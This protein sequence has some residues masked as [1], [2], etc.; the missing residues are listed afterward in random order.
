MTI[1]GQTT[2]QFHKVRLKALGLTGGAITDKFQFHKVRLKE[3]ACLRVILF[4]LVS[5][6]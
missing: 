4:S 5:I 2:F 3:G 1:I 6:P